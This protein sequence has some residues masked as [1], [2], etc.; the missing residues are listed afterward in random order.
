MLGSADN[1]LLRND[2]IRLLV[3]LTQPAYLCF[4]G[5]YP[6]K[7][8]IDM[9]KCFMEVNKYLRIYKE[10]GLLLLKTLLYYAK[11]TYINFFLI[12]RPLQ[13]SQ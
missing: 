5:A 3:N 8:D 2:V 6:Q 9:M 12:Y 10:V 7:K 4:G 13:K 1:I 11:L